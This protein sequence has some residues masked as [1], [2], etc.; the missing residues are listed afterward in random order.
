MENIEFF[1]LTIKQVQTVAGLEQKIGGV[2]YL[3]PS[4]HIRFNIFSEIDDEPI[5]E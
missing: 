4:G 3:Q 1:P 5:L 2:R